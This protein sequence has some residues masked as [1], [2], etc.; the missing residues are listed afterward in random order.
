[1]LPSTR[2]P[3]RRPSSTRCSAA[4]SKHCFYG[5]AQAADAPWVNHGESGLYIHYVIR[6]FCISRSSAVTRVFV[7]TWAQ[8]SAQN[9]RRCAPKQRPLETNVAGTYRRWQPYASQLPKQLR[10]LQFL[11]HFTSTCASRHN[12][13]HFFNISTSK[14]GPTLRCFVPFHFE[15]ASRHNSVQLFISHLPRC[16]RTRRFSEPTFQ[17]Q[18]NTVFRDF[19]IFSRTCIF[20]LL[21]FSLLT[22]LPADCF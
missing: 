20:F 2:C 14:S 1:M 22:L 5:Q 11:T 21:I 9:S 18:K 10:N 4:K 3:S 17:P 13:V 15:K 19:P 8:V 7:L 6:C 12:A 16:L